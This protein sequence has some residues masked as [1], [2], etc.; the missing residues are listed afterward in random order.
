MPFK[1]NIRGLSYTKVK[2]IS[3]V[4]MSIK[5]VEFVLL[6]KFKLALGELEVTCGHSNFR[7]KVIITVYIFNLQK[8]LFVILL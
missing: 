3:L 5:L 1:K 6:M 4:D 8:I 2:L 7:E